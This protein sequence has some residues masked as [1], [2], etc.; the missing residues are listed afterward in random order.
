[1]IPA[2]SLAF[3]RRCEGAEEK[4]GVVDHP[5]DRFSSEFAGD[6]DVSNERYGKRYR[7]PVDNEVDER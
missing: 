4:V 7:S 5:P 1:M 6:S 2:G 3:V